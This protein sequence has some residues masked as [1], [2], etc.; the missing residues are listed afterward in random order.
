MHMPY[1]NKVAPTVWLRCSG[2]IKVL[3]AAG[4]P[5][6]VLARAETRSSSQGFKYAACIHARSVF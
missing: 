5:A 6:K 4:G 2:V 1:L 3:P